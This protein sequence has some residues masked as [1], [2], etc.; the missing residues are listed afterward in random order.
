MKEYIY[1]LEMKTRDYE[2]DIQ[3]VVNNANYQH[4]LEVTRHEFLESAGVSFGAWHAQGIDVM[5]A[6]ITMEYKTPLQGSEPFLSCLNLRKEGIRFIFDQDIYRKSDQ[7]LCLHAEVEC[8][9]LANGRLT[10]GEIIEEP[11]RKYLQQTTTTETIPA[12]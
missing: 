9:C 6:K 12:K 8:V 7:R 10:R 3:G 2:C 5:V 1:T 4:Y 11:F